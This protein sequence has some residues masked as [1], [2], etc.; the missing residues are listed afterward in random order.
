MDQQLVKVTAEPPIA[1]VV[2]DHPPVNALGRA[3]LE[4]L[5]A[6]AEQVNADARVKC[7]IVTGGGQ[8]AF[9][10]GA[11]IAEMGA[12]ATADDVEKL[13]R[14]G[15]TAFARIEDAPK[16][17]IAAVN[18]VC[19]GGGLELAMACHLRIAGDRAKLGQPEIN[20]GTIPA[21][22]GS[23]RLPRIVGQAEAAELLLT[24]DQIAATE[25]LRIG[26]VNRVV[27]QAEVMK[28]AHDLARRIA[29][30]SAVA[31]RHLMQ[32]VGRSREASLEAGFEM[33]VRAARELAGSADSREG[34]RAFLEKRQPVFTD[35]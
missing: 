32:L 14:L 35:R 31:V 9:V 26:L 6:A 4:Q 2:I 30:K 13:V 29:S 22:G 8:M 33:E 27:P 3:V 15:Q 20:L 17:W 23:Q 34:I 28:H 16:P 21:F 11:D 7:V 18:G 5:A 25:A 19:L 12:L 24:G 1:V 10:A